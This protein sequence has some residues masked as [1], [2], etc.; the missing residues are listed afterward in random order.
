M[1]ARCEHARLDVVAAVAAALSSDGFA[2]VDVAPGRKHVMNVPRDHMRVLERCKQPLDAIFQEAS[3]RMVASGDARR[4]SF[5][6]P[7]ASCGSPPEVLDVDDPRPPQRLCCCGLLTEQPRATRCGVAANARA[8]CVVPC[9]VDDGSAPVCVDLS[10][11]IHAAVEAGLAVLGTDYEAKEVTL[12][13]TMP[14]AKQQVFHCDFPASYIQ[15]AA[16]HGDGQDRQP[17][18]LL[19]ALSHAAKCVLQCASLHTTL[20]SLVLFHTACV[21][22]R[23]QGCRAAALTQGHAVLCV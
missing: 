7:C 8:S 10:A 14:G 17:Y 19:A 13:R 20:R 18:V 16:A 6:F 12:L 22:A 23:S 21:C 2:V 3:A 11:Q 9:V 15:R 5:V 4:H 1:R